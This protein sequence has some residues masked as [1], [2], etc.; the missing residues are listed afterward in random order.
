MFWNRRPNWSG[1]ERIT[2]SLKLVLLHANKQHPGT[3]REERSGRESKE[4]KRGRLVS[5]GGGGKKGLWVLVRAATE[6]PGPELYL[7]SASD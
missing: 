3:R 7:T 6:Q 1:R 4:R 5:V 2:G